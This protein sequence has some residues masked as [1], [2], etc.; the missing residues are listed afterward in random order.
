MSSSLSLGNV[1]TTSTGSSSFA[2]IASGI[3]TTAL[4]TAEI[5][6][7]SLPMQTLQAEQSANTSTSSAMSSLETQMSTLSTDL[8]TMNTSGFQAR[9][10]TSSDSTNSHVT[11]TASGGAS[12]TFTVAVQNTA[13]AA[14]ISPATDSSGNATTLAVANASDP[15]FSGTSDTFAI[16]D[17]N[18]NTQQVTLSGGNNTINALADA[19]NALQTANPSVP[20]STGL[21]VQATVVNTGTGTNPYELILTS[22]TTGSGTA[23]STIKIAD[24][25]TLPNSSTPANTIGIP[26][27]TLNAAS[28]AALTPTLDS[29]GNPTSLA[30]ADPDATAV[31]TG[32]TGQFSIEDTNGH[33]QTITLGGSSGNANSLNGLVSAINSA[34]GLDVKATTSLASNGDTELTLTSTNSGVGS[35][36]SNLTIADTTGGSTGNALNIGAGT[37]NA[38]GTTIISGGTQSN[39]AAANANSAIAS[40][41]TTSAAATNAVFT[42]DGIKLTRS[43]NSVSDAVNGITFNLLQG[44]QS[45]TTTL[46]VAPDVDTATADMQQVITDYNTLMST[47]NTDS[48]TGGPLSGNYGAQSLITRIQ[49][50]LTGLPQG[51]STG[52]TY[53]SAASLGISTNNDG[54]LTLDTTAFRTAISTNPTAAQN[55]FANA[56]TSTNAEVS[57]GAAGPNT[58]TGNIGFDITS[59]ISGGALAGT[60]TAP[61]GKTYNVT[62]DN[63]IIQGPAGSTLAGLYLNV[64]GTGSGT[65]TLSQGVGQQTINAISNMTNEASGT[66]TQMLKNI[67]NQNT[68]LTTQISSQQTM[69]NT[70]QASLEAQ[71]NQMEATL[72]QLQ[73]AGQSVSSLA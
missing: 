30:V 41:G 59:F 1:S 14:Q 43:S 39:Q 58:A 52:A 67:T 11:A 64:T 27:G 68:Q 6:Q 36:G 17:T 24:L 55:V 13:T 5:A 62:G 15:I 48:A 47:Y 28:P 18:G 49:S 40:G 35:S 20:G 25:S 33:T 38:G 3:N 45:G 46:T 61:D 57:L 56:A 37:L 21:G 22:A 7:A 73:S 29:S 8:G 69:L 70:L 54:S 2:G 32:G 66:I 10:V 12:G 71:Y 63:G 60:L 65:L 9:I 50:A 53:N 26:A 51:L 16:E 72:S 23:G 44:N 19:I 34:S 31:F 42:L 4:V